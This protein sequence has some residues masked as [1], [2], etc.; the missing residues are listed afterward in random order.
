MF[1]RSIVVPAVAPA[2][3]VAGL[4]F[5]FALT[6]I[7][8]SASDDVVCTQQIDSRITPG[9]GAPGSVAVV[10]WNFGVPGPLVVVTWDGEA[11]LNG[12]A[13]RKV[14]DCYQGVDVPIPVDAATGSHEVVVSCAYCLVPEEYA[15]VTFTVTAAPSPTATVSP[16][17]AGS[18]TPP[19]PRPP[20]TGSG[21][22][23]GQSLPAAVIGG[24]CLLF[25]AGVA[26]GIRQAASG[27]VD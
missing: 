8:V 15:R 7:G 22:G 26:A 16:S 13:T 19:A 24:L 11:L 17:P 20:N 1:V 6:P 25:A 2:I 27:N 4:L 3:L 18:P 14:D 12:V 9:S 10:S 23:G 21:A 5:S